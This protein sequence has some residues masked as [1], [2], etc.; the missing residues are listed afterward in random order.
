MTTSVSN[1]H[2]LPRSVA[3]AVL[4]LCGTACA[5]DPASTPTAAAAPATSAAPAASTPLSASLLVPVT[6]LIGDAACD[7]QSQ[8]HVVGIGAK[9]CG[10][11]SGY[12]AWSDRKT[13]A[14]ALRAA[15]AAQARAQSDE[16]KAS[17]LLSDCMVTPTPP[18]VCRPRGSDGRKACQLGQGGA[19]SAV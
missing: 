10:G 15:V 5:I 2:S 19:S 16:N 7:N 17:G 3:L 14:D 6:T 12:L 13:D 9:A 8:C 11:P 1:P 4:T 18:A